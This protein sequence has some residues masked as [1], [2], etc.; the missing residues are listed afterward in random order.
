MPTGTPADPLVLIA[1]AAATAV[2]AK[3]FVIFKE[4]ELPSLF[5][6]RVRWN[7]RGKAAEEGVS[8]MINSKRPNSWP[9]TP[10]ACRC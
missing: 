5:R 10:G 3:A 6:G 2:A 1:D 8:A 7:A 9:Q 4:P